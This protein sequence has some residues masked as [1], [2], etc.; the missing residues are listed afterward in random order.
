[1]PPGMIKAG[2]GVATGRRGDRDAVG[3][4]KTR[5]TTLLDDLH[6]PK[7]MVR[8]FRQ[9][10]P[11]RIRSWIVNMMSRPVYG[12]LSALLCLG[13][14][15][16]S[17]ETSA[18]T[19]NEVSGEVSVLTKSSPVYQP[20]YNNMALPLK[21]QVQTK[22]AAKAT[23]T[24]S[25]GCVVK[26]DQNYPQFIIDQPDPCNG[27]K[28]PK[29]V[30]VACPPLAGAGAAGGWGLTAAGGPLG[31]S[32]TGLALGGLGAAAVIGGVAGGIAASSGSSTSAPC[33]ISP[34]V[35]GCQ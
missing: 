30:A 29:K 19:L 27:G 25:S 32:T 14:A 12:V 2:L 15:P 5:T 33:A 17:A 28:P 9:D 10:L 6:F 35:P 21:T 7:V 4:S 13:S 22:C 24:Y 26:L 18:A 11:Q 1:M 8:I 3:K 34:T 16:A 23:V 31:L 20:G